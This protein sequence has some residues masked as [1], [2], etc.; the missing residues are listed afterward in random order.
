MLLCKPAEFESLQGEVQQVKQQS[1]WFC[2]YFYTQSPQQH[3]RSNLAS[4]IPKWQ[5]CCSRYAK[6]F[7]VMVSAIGV[8]ILF[9]RSVGLQSGHSQSSSPPAAPG[10]EGTRL[11]PESLRS[12]ATFQSTSDACLG[13]FVA[14]R[15]IVWA[16][17]C[18][19]PMHCFIIEVFLFSAC[20]PGSLILN[21]QTYLW[22]VLK[23]MCYDPQEEQIPQMKLIMVAVRKTFNI[24]RNLTFCWQ[25][26]MLESKSHTRARVPQECR[27]AILPI[28]LY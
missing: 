11:E 14:N 16:R 5:F 15:E 9:G 18:K 22:I 20:W 24:L 2:R 1:M 26:Q 17:D 21:H 12:G 4:N 6:A 28:D 7:T 19:M 13:F 3:T 8:Y 25:C 23:C 10:S 27:L